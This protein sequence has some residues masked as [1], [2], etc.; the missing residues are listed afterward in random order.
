MNIDKCK[1]R[2]FCDTKDL[3]QVPI[4]HSNLDFIP[5]LTSTCLSQE[6]TTRIITLPG[7]F[8]FIKKL[9]T[10]FSIRSPSFVCGSS[11]KQQM[12]YHCKMKARKITGTQYLQRPNSTV[13]SCNLYVYDTTFFLAFLCFF[14]KMRTMQSNNENDNCPVES[15]FVGY[16]TH[17]E[18]SFTNQGSYFSRCMHFLSSLCPFYPNSHHIGNYKKQAAN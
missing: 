10:L 8:S 6:E 7:Q 4:L 1:K 9:F 11:K 12:F 3:S 15:F 18:K 16:N 5:G 14:V 2:Y 13:W 17:L